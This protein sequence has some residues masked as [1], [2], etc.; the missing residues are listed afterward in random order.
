MRRDAAPFGTLNT[1]VDDHVPR[2]T[3]PGQAAV[4]LAGLVI[5][6]ILMSIQL[7]LLTVA[8]DLYLGGGGDSVWPLAIVSGVVFLG[9]ILAVSLLDR[10]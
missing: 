2:H 3:P 10:R 9:G 4:L 7:W 5:G 6:A 8:L 1:G